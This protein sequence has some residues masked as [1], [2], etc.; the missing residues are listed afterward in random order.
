MT[1]VRARVVDLAAAAEMMNEE[2]HLHVD[3]REISTCRLHHV[4]VL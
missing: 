3:S 1:K 2:G 4:P